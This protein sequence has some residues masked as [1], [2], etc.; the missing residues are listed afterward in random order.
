MDESS[1]PA[2][3]PVKDGGGALTHKIVPVPVI[4]HDDGNVCPLSKG[5]KTCPHEDDLGQPNFGANEGLDQV[6][7]VPNIRKL[8]GCYDIAVKLNKI[9]ANLPNGLNG[10]RVPG[11]NLDN[12]EVPQYPPAIGSGTSGFDT[13]SSVTSGATVGVR[14]DSG[15]GDSVEGTA[16]SGSAPLIPPQPQSQGFLPGDDDF[17]AELAALEEVDEDDEDTVK[18][19]PDRSEFK[20][21]KKYERKQRTALSF[22]TSVTPQQLAALSPTLK[23]SMD[24]FINQVEQVRPSKTV[25]CRVSQKSGLCSK[26]RSTLHTA[27]MGPK[28]LVGLEKISI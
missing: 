20:E 25:Q 6:H 7:S 9:V 15:V 21:Y 4:F 12:L 1:D 17:S 8:A 11:L 23:S 27:M 14:T 22:L 16:S 28:K 26:L 18:P 2:P 10:L 3:P 5:E 19:L 24:N 13:S